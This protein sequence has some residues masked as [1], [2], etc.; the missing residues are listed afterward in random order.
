MSDSTNVVVSQARKFDIAFAALCEIAAVTKFVRRNSAGKAAN[1]IAAAA[2]EK[3]R[4]LDRSE[5]HG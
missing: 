5:R 1:N 4:V 2:L 3:L